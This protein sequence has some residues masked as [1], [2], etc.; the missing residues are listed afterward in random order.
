MKTVRITLV[1]V[2]IGSLLLSVMPMS[3]AQAADTP[4]TEELLAQCAMA[5][6]C[7]F[8]PTNNEQFLSDPEM[9]AP[10][11]PNCYPGVVDSW[12]SW[13]NTKS[14]S[15]S[16]GGSVTG[17]VDIFEVYKAAFAVTYNH[18]WT[19]S[20]TTGSALTLHVPQGN[21][22]YVTTATVMS[23][24][25]GTWELHF[26]NRFY[27]H[28]YWYTAPVSVEGP[29]SALQNSGVIL[30]YNRPMTDSERITNCGK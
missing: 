27:G 21:I 17:S 10:R 8:T 13:S 5:D 9:A 6:Y 16:V 22:G 4:T 18:E 15:D 20:Q 30:P 11:V 23:R 3:A 2:A 24:V 7:Q 25:T 29:D 1:A 12:T 26:A 14:T 19:S 28:Y